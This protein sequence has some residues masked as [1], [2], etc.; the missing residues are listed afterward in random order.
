MLKP[1]SSSITQNLIWKMSWKTSK[2]WERFPHCQS[3]I[4]SVHWSFFLPGDMFQCHHLSDLTDTLLCQ[5]VTIFGREREKQSN[6]HF[7]FSEK[8][9]GI[10]ENNALVLKLGS[11]TRRPQGLAEQ[12]SQPGANAYHEIVTPLGWG[13]GLSISFPVLVLTWLEGTHTDPQPR[14]EWHSFI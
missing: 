7:Y 4:S 13:T 14:E 10:T 2:K 11:G 5:D 6:L 8:S 3:C 12:P 9:W 1:S